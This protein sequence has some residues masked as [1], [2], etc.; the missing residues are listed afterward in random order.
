MLTAICR[1]IVCDIEACEAVNLFICPSVPNF[2]ICE[3][4]IS[5]HLIGLMWK[6]IKGNI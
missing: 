1:P 4:A 2:F 5:M 3:H 6:L